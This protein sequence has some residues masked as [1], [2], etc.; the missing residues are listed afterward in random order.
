MINFIII[1]ILGGILSYIITLIYYYYYYYYNTKIICDNKKE[2]LE[3]A[4]THVGN[5]LEAFI[6]CFSWIYF[7]IFSTYVSFKL[8]RI[9][10]Y[11]LLEFLLTFNNNEKT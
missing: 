6:W 10:C 7:I 11:K 9:I 8:I 2:Q 5:K 1:H 3:L 4:K